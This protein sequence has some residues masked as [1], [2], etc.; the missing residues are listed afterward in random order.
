M[1]HANTWEPNGLYR[2][3]TGEVSGEEI[4]MSNIEH[5]S[6]N[7]FKDI[8][9]VINNF[10]EVTGH[11]IEMGHTEIFASTDEIISRT[12]HQ[13]KIA[14]VVP[15]GPMLDLAKN[16]CELMRQQV[17]DCDIFHSLESARHWVNSES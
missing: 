6:D 17:F 5:H 1:A 3:F 13:L 14:L 9:Y 7:R 2:L 16:Y 8:N 10:L 15:E 12:K 11:S 4:F